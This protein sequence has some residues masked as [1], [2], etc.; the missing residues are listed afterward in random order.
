MNRTLIAPF[1]LLP[2]LAVSCGKSD[3]ATPPDATPPDAAPADV[4]S[5]RVLAGTTVTLGEETHRFDP[6]DDGYVTSTGLRFKVEADR[7]KVKGADGR[8]LC[9]VKK[10]DDGFKAYRNGAD[11]AFLRGKRRGDGF[12]LSK[13]PSD[14]EMG[15]IEK[16]GGTVSGEAIT[17]EGDSVRRAGTEVGTA[18]GL[19]AT[20]AAMLGL[21][22][23]SAAERLALVVY[24]TE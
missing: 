5:G 2:A 9:K 19:P 22:E 1:L 3:D 20:V 12:K 14:E 8:E 17:V 24:A 13:K 18:P 16:G 23:L 21:T 6:K 10:K 7:V 15:R 11:D 4:A